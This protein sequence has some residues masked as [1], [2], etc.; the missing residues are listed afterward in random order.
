MKI[1]SI[2]MIGDGRS[3]I[4]HI[5][6]TEYK[7][8]YQRMSDIWIW[9]I[10]GFKGEKS[11]YLPIFWRDEEGIWS[12]NL[13]PFALIVNLFFLGNLPSCYWRRL[14]NLKISFILNKYFWS[15]LLLNFN[16]DSFFHFIIQKKFYYVILW[17]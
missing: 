12:R 6:I 2:H 10:Q 14:Q 5:H 3:N 11:N 4:F 16:K 17:F 13:K 9:E 1:N 7:D 15:K 8:K